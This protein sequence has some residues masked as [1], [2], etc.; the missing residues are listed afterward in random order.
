MASHTNASSSSSWLFRP[1]S[2]TFRARPPP[3]FFCSIF[4]Y[5]R[6][7]SP[8]TAKNLSLTAP[9]LLLLL[10]SITRYYEFT[11]PA[12]FFFRSRQIETL[13]T[14]WRFSAKKA[15]S[16]SVLPLQLA[17]SRVRISAVPSPRV[18][19]LGYVTPRV[20]ARRKTINLAY[21]RVHFSGLQEEGLDLEAILRPSVIICSGVIIT[22]AS[23]K[24]LVILGSG[25]LILFSVLGEYV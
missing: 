15:S 25:S 16:S 17:F 21:L 6:V 18:V 19:K 20:W 13:A 11:G 4:Y 24:T 23:C 12:S 5:F 10:P 9:C 3:S 2:S 1:K 14:S 7:T 22:A 8:T